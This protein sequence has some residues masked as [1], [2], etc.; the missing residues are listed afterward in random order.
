MVFFKLIFGQ[1]IVFIT[2]HD[3]VSEQTISVALIQAK[4]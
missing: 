1:N 3:L 2:T 4:A